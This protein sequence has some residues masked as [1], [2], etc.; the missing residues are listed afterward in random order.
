MTDFK[1]FHQELLTL[2]KKYEQDTPLKM[3]QDLENDIVK[4]FGAKIT[5]L[6][7]A[8]NGLNDMTELAYTTAEHHPYWNLLYNCSEIAHTV[9]DK[10]NKSLS[11]NDLK[12]IDWALKEIY[13]TLEKIKDSASLEH[14]C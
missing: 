14:D 13:Q 8:Q 12:D 2:I 9:L 3:E 7:R 5:S 11:S 1:N 10:W 4:I 6:A